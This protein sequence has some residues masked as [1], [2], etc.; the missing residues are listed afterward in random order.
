MDGDSG[1]FVLPLINSAYTLDQTVNG[2]VGW[3]WK[4]EGG[5]TEGF[6]RRTLC[7]YA[8][9]LTGPYP[10]DSIRNSQPSTRNAK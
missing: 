4:V 5:K 8:S 1:Q 9:T 2:K 6:V 10:Q 7:P 3:K